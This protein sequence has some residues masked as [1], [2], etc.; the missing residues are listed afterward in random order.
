MLKT[1]SSDVPIIQLI[2]PLEHW[3]SVSLSVCVCLFV[4]SSKTTDPHE[5]LFVRVV[6]LK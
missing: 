4:K 3:M 6:I 5:L 1:I 2:Y